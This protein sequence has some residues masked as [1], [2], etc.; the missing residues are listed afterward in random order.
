[1]VQQT[2]LTGRQEYTA[3]IAEAILQLRPEGETDVPSFRS[4]GLYWDD[5]REIPDDKLHGVL[6]TLSAEIECRQRVGDKQYFA[7]RARGAKSNIYMQALIATED[8]YDDEEIGPD[9][10]TSW[11]EFKQ[12]FAHCLRQEMEGPF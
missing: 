4:F 3:R 9:L 10:P 7:T 1:M 2:T 12:R 6:Q 5:I 8:S 11:V